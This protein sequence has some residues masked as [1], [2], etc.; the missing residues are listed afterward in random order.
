MFQTE[1]AFTL[2]CGFIDPEG[3][4]IRHGVMRRAT[5][6]DEIEPLGDRR[7]QTNEAY[8]SILLLSRVV[9]RLGSFS[10]VEPQIIGRLFASDFLFLQE[11]YERINESGNSLIET[12]CPTC[13]ARFAL[14]T[15]G[16][17]AA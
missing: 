3:N 9:V 16:A 11:L 5:A 8:L 2:P 15:A 17:E 14:D 12:Q 1:F 4:L 10:P 6:L 7:V 13:G